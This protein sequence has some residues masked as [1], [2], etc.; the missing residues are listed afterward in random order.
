M[1]IKKLQSMKER[2]KNRTIDLHT[3]EI[4]S[5]FENRLFWTLKAHPKG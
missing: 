4:V 1:P 2:E 3:L 5:S